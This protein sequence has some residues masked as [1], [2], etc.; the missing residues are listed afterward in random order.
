MTQDLQN[1][2]KRLADRFIER[3]EFTRSDLEAAL[4]KLPDLKDAAEDISAVIYG[5]TA[6]EG[7]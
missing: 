4:E 3:G 5:T 1:V 2:D 7:E 6:N